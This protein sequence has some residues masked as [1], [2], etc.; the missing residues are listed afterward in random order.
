MTGR[1]NAVTEWAATVK[2]HC[3]GCRVASLHCP[4]CGGGMWLQ[5]PEHL[6]LDR[7]W[8]REQ[9]ICPNC[10]S[11]GAITIDGV[12]P[13]TAL[14]RAVEAD[15]AD[16][17]QQDPLPPLQRKSAPE[18]IR[19]DW[20]VAETARQQFVSHPSRKGLSASLS[21]AAKR[22]KL[23]EPLRSKPRLYTR[24][25]IELCIHD[26]ARRQRQQQIALK[27]RFNREERQRQRQQQG[28]SSDSL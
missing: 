17:P 23:A 10:E 19:S 7:P 20:G 2:V 6:D 25:E 24:A 16:R 14:E 13:R 27:H 18:W 21:A 9:N 11:I 26:V 8:T 15:P 22:L 12:D 5:L 3:P 28:V 4:A 1:L